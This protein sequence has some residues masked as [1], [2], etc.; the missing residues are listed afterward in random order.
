MSPAKRQLKMRETKEN[1]L[2]KTKKDGGESE[3]SR[4]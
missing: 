4:R 3:E 2:N 1:V